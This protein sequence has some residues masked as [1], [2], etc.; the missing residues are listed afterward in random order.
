M[1]ARL[2]ETLY[3]IST[4]NKGGGIFNWILNKLG[5][6]TSVRNMEK[7]EVLDPKRLYFPWHLLKSDD[8]DTIY[9]IDR[10]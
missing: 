8:D 7:S 1:E 4:D 5:L 3:P 2:V 10:R 6:E 9:I